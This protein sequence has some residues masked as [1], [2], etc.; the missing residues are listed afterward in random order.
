MK[1]YLHTEYFDALVTNMSGYCKLQFRHI[2]GLPDG[3][4]FSHYS[5]DKHHCL[6][7]PVL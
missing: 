4:N 2:L 3:T 5:N 7:I 6:E 1:Q